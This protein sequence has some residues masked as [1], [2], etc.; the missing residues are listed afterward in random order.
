MQKIVDFSLTVLNADAEQNMAKIFTWYILAPTD[1]F[2]EDRSPHSSGAR[3]NFTVKLQV[4][5]KE[6]PIRINWI[7]VGL[8]I[9]AC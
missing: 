1:L 5:T 7:L 9:C 8:C 4:Y 2:R 3:T 6:S